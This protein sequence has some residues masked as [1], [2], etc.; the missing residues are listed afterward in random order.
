M[1][2]SI[3]ENKNFTIINEILTNSQIEGL[4]VSYIGRACIDLVVP[5]NVIPTIAEVALSRGCRLQI[6]GF[7]SSEGYFCKITE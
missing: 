5:V 2:N 3:M 7:A 4:Y 6:T 1:K